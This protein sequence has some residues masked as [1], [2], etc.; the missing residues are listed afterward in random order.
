MPGTA[1]GGRRDGAT[2]LGELP[3]PHPE[4]CGRRGGLGPERRMGSWLGWVMSGMGKGGGGSWGGMKKM[5][6]ESAESGIALMRTVSMCVSAELRKVTQAFFL[7]M[8]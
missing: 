6:R 4:T 5:G 1:E 3:A 8:R 2:Q 7:L